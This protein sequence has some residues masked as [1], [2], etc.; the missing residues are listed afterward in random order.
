[1]FDKTITQNDSICEIAILVY[2]KKA[3]HRE[4]FLVDEKLALND[5]N[6]DKCSLF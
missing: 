3:K 2:K 5:S 4:Y 6:T 1:N